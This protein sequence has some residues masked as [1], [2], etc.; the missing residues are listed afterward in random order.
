[1][2]HDKSFK[3]LLKVC[4]KLKP[5]ELEGVF[6]NLSDAGVDKICECVYNVIH[7][8]HVCA[9]LSKGRINKLK[10]HIKTK[11]NVKNIKKISDR[12]ISVSKRRKLIKQEG[13]G[14]GMLMSTVIPFLL[15]TVKSKPLNDFAK[16]YIPLS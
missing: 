2:D 7:N 10:N 11:C 9:K 5:D 13:G 1:M 12:K 4:A 6:E 3:S 16:T 8:E 14:L 15:R